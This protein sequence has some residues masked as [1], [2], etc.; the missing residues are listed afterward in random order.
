MHK[1]LKGEGPEKLLEMLEPMKNTTAIS[2]RGTTNNNLWLPAYNTNYMTYSFMCDAAKLW[3]K[4]PS[5]LK[6][7]K[8][9]LTFKEQLHKYFFT[10]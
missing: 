2:T 7:I 4:I 3:N 8:N 1:L 10:K 9:S 5:S 6:E